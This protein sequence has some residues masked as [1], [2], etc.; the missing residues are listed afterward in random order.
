MNID[1]VIKKMIASCFIVILLSFG[2]LVMAENVRT[3]TPKELAKYNGQNGV[4]SYVA[5]SGVVYDLTT[6]P[7]WANG[8]HFCQGA[9]A[10]KDLT[11]LWNLVPPSHKDPAFL[12][13]F[14]VVGKMVNTK[15]QSSGAPSLPST[16]KSPSI[17]KPIV[18]GLVIAIMITLGWFF[19]RVRK[20]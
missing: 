4:P 2:S 13:R 1:R 10:G 6:V 15:S 8:R 7:E 12:K 3:F 16:Q 9:I 20:H 19:Y 14:T 11:F 17:L 18:L 5:V